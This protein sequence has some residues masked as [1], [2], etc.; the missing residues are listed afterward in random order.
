MNALVFVKCNLNF[1]ARHEKRQAKG[2]LYDPVSLSDM[3]SDNEWITESELPCLQN[4]CSWMDVQ[5]C[6]NE[7]EGPSDM[8][9]RRGIYL[10]LFQ[11]LNN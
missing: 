5:E 3:E 4:D 7:D 6:F 10:S 11:V 1:E 9:R 8:K 2:E